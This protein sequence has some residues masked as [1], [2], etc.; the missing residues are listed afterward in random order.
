MLADAAKSAG[1]KDNITVVVVF[2]KPVKELIGKYITESDALSASEKESLLE[3]L[4]LL[5]QSH[6]SDESGRSWIT[7]DSS[8]SSTDEDD[9]TSPVTESRTSGCTI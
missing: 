5:D 7:T 9:N 3:K 4:K 1:S 2:L 8:A 6:S